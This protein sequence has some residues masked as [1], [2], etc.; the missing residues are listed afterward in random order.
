PT[1]APEPP[2]VVDAPPRPAHAT[3]HD[4]RSGR[5]LRHLSAPDYEPLPPE[6]EDPYG[7][8]DPYA[9]VGPA[10]AGR[11]ANLTFQDGEDE[12]SYDDPGADTTTEAGV[13]VLLRVLGGRVLE[14]RTGAD[15]Q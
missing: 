7:P 15:A 10:S 9:P 3:V 8:E 4:I 12:I 11:A 5:Q 14:E 6:P 13:H 2:P 1:P